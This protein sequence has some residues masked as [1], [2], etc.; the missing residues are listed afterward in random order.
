ML[1]RVLRIAAGCVIVSLS[2][3]PPARAGIQ[4]IERSRALYREAVVARENRDHAAYLERMRACARLRPD[5]PE[6][7]YALATAYALN[8]DADSALVCLDRIAEMGLTAPAR[9]DS[10]FIALA[11]EKRFKSAL[12]R[13]DANTQP[14]MTCRI[15]FTLPQQDLV[16]EGLAYEP[17]SRSFFV[18][19]VRDRKIMRYQRG[20]IT[21]FAG[22]PA[23]SLWSM[24]G[25]KLDASR[26]RL[27]VATA[28]IREGRGLPAKDLGRTGVLAF[29]IRTGALSSARILPED[30]AQH[31]FG[32]LTLDAHGDVLVTDSAGGGLYRV[33]A[34]GGAPQVLIPPGT[35][36][37]PQGLDMAGDGT[38]LYLSDYSQGVF[39]V[40][41][42]TG[43]ATL[44]RHPPR[45]T[46]LGIDGL[47]RHGNTLIA[48]QNGVRP[49]RVLRL[50]LSGGG[51]RIEAIEVLESSLPIFDDPTLGV[52]VGDAFYFIANSHWPQFD[53][54]GNLPPPERLTPPTILRV[55]LD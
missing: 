41:L 4:E 13:L 50:T 6:L 32:D 39:R 15:A 10:S 46:L 12:D 11:G 35:F 31:L 17:G 48:V 33:A 24:M 3:L 54:D 20:E 53:A 29:D 28:A 27:W 51:E 26:G 47:Y 36:L 8:G 38:H 22:G 5:H 40:D 37:S 55:A 42:G 19:S 16:P 18:S 1:T 49:Q 44:M 52:I 7:L 2:C 25:M 21:R 9:E 45:Q 43:T 30:G 23:D 14:T 34:A